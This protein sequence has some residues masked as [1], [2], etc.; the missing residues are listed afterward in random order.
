MLKMFEEPIENTYFFL[1]I[2][3]KNTLISTFISRFYFITNN[4]NESLYSK[5]VKIL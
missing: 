2:R 1:I 5:E 4:S 3:D